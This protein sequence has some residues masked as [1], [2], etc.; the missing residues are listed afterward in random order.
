MSKPEPTP[1][2]Q[3]R[4]L[5]PPVIR[6][7]LAAGLLALLTTTSAADGVPSPEAHLGFRPGA[8]ER[9]AAWADVVAYFRAVDRASDRV[10]LRE[11]GET[12]EGRPMIAAVVASPSTVRDLDR[13]RTVQARLSDPRTFAAPADAERALRESKPVVVISCSIHSTETA[14]TLMAM[15]LLHGLA[16]GDDPATREVLDSTILLLVPSANPDGVDKVAR[17]YE[18]SK[19][20]PWVGSG[21]P[22]LYHKYAGHDTNRDWFMLNLKETQLLSR[23]Y[24]REWFPTLLYDVHQMGGKGARLFVPPFHDPI[25]PNLDPR[26][27]QGIFM[28]G[29]H[30]AADLASAGK[31][32][33]LTHAMYDNW[34]NGG[35]RTTPQRHNI[36][37][38]LTEAASVKIA[39]PVFVDKDE[40]RGATRGFSDHGP[41][42]NFVDPWPGGW[43]RL[44]DIVDYELVCARSLLTLAARYGDRF[45]SNLLAMARDAVAKG[46]SEP[47]YAWVVPA[48]QRDVGSAARLLRALHDTG[49]E[50]GRANGSFKAGEVEYP[51]GSWVIPAAQPYRT[52]V[53]DMLERQVYPTRLT[54]GGRAE[55]PYDVAGWTLPLQ[56]GVRVVEVAEPLKVEAERLDTIEAPK[57]GI[58]RTS[59]DSFLTLPN[60]AND[61]TTVICALLAAKVDLSL[62]VRQTGRNE[63]PVGAVVFRYNESSGKVLDAVLPALSS[64]VVRTEDPA[65]DVRSGAYRKVAPRR[66]ALYQPWAPS[67]DEGWT[68][69]VL[70]RFKIPY[71]T[72]HNADVRA[73]ELKERIDVLLIP[74]IDPKTLASGYGTDESAPDYVGG[75]GTDGVAALRAFLRDGGRLVCLDSS[76]EYAIDALHLPVK[77]VLKG[78]STATFYAPGSI[79]RTTVGAEPSTI[80]VG[81]PHE[82]PVYFDRSMAFEATGRTGEVHVALRYAESNPLESGWLLGPEKIEGKAALVELEV[83]KGKVILFGFRPQHRGQTHGTFRLL[84]NALL[85]P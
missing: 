22:E 66:V 70:E 65:A 33:V 25:N 76:C 83:S 4:R 53:K 71:T 58:D 80:T 77:N 9:L 10:A 32:G 37:A 48:D 19:G 27:H 67:M 57:G 2:P 85:L 38:V 63:P 36:V 78:L 43:W 20:H 81:M 31:R 14:S 50:V 26:L 15:E 74:S 84:F 7:G 72:V 55:P 39:T 5:I 60:Q 56:M 82:V 51:S 29:A 40:L 61:D 8:D 1:A 69:L 6:A 42:V 64:R 45:Q 24:Y 34:W 44:R 73:G 13:Y 47:P 23:L 17:W 62:R 12:T 68:R 28:I 41:A 46:S 30:M 3:S 16:K 18:R 79:L 21:M 35:N 59:S 54:A 52:H 75:L 11:L 49:V